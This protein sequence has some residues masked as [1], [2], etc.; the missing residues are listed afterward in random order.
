MGRFDEKYTRGQKDACAA[1]VLDGKRL[2]GRHIFPKEVVRMAAAGELRDQA[3]FEITLSTVRKEAT[4]LRREKTGRQL[5]LKRAK[6]TVEERLE[7][8]T[9]ATVSIVEHA[10]DRLARQ[11]RAKGLNAQQIS[12]LKGLALV[13][14]EL[15]A[16]GQAPASH[17]GQGAR[18]QP[19]AER[20]PEPS[21]NE[22]ETTSPLVRDMIRDH[23]E[24]PPTNAHTP[25]DTTTE[26]T[27]PD[28]PPR[29]NTTEHE[30]GDAGA[31]A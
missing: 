16:R 19:P 14:R 10:L 28:L 2:Y 11:E 17:T 27:N 12:D 23:E 1:A 15:R 25:S 30:Q 5:D 18:K 9:A 22:S 4:R 7:A 3:P 20:T 6:G 8:T 31:I 21:A 26:N 13:Q 29:T 24:A